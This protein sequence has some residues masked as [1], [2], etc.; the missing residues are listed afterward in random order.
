MVQQPVRQRL[1]GDTGQEGQRQNV[2]QE[3]LRPRPERAENGDR[4]PA[5]RE[6]SVQSDK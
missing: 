1:H 3:K 2:S 5:H 6:N 4:R